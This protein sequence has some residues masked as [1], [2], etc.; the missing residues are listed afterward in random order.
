MKKN[1]FAVIVLAMI[2]TTSLPVFAASQISERETAQIIMQHVG[3]EEANVKDASP[4]IAAGGNSTKI[5]ELDDVRDVG[6]GSYTGWIR[7]NPNSN[8]SVLAHDFAR[9]A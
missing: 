4:E 9:P 2:L 6:D 1:L 7:Y 5:I 8:F 3:V